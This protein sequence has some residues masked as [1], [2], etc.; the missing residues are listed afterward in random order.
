M[1]RFQIANKWFQVTEDGLAQLNSLLNGP[2]FQPLKQKYN[3]KTEKYDYENVDKPV[4]LGTEFKTVW[5]GG[6]ED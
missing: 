6:Q 2:G 3:N 5:S 1:I 4:K